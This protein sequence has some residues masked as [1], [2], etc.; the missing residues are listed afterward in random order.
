MNQAT[1]AWM[2]FRA[3]NAPEMMPRIAKIA[4]PTASG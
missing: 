1:L 4:P 2:W 3:S